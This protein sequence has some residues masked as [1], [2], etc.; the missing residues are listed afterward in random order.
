M[1]VRRRPLGPRREVT[2]AT[3]PARG[4]C[5]ARSRRRPV[6]V[7]LP[8]AA[9]PL[10]RGVALAATVA[11]PASTLVVSEVQTGGRSRRRTSS[12]RSRTRALGRSTSSG[13]RWSMRRRVGLDRH[14]QG[15]LGASTILLAW[16]ADP[17]RERRRFVCRARR[18]RRTPAGSPRPVG[19]SRFGSSAGRV[20]DAVGWGDATN[21]FV[22]GSP[23]RAACGIEPGAAPWRRGRQRD[24]HERQRDG[25]VHLGHAG[26]AE[27]G[28]AGRARRH[29]DTDADAEP[30]GDTDVRRRLRHRLRPRLRLPRRIPTAT[31]MPTGAPTPT[32][33]PTP[34][35]TPT[36]APTPEPTRTD[37]DT[38][39][40]GRP[41]ALAHPD[42]DA[43]RLADRR[44][45]P[46][47]LKRERCPTD[48]PPRSPGC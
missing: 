32:P 21:A 2:H 35:P 22:E 39:T 20:I 16:P 12:S 7:G 41:V 27:P 18:T 47:S 31:P 17:A 42:A 19:R 46:R 38:G 25:L 1:A 40:D 9:S 6:P 10:G 33:T 30:H 15:D 43:D 26:C 5:R 14:A 8:A 34:E 28:L 11:W 48:P 24:R 4:G 45:S 44:R 13:S 3:R 23:R 29:A 36:T 37:T